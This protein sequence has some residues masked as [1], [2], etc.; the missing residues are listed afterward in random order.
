MGNISF[1]ELEIEYFGGTPWVAF[2]WFSGFFQHLGDFFDH[3]GSKYDFYLLT[4]TPRG[5]SLARGWPL[6]ENGF[7]GPWGPTLG[8]L[9]LVRPL[10]DPLG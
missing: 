2:G 7:Q 5:P 10:G 1:S 3:R 9:S 4:P 6:R 8:R